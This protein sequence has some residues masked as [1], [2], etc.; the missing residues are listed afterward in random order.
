M[1]IKSLHQILQEH[2]PEC[3]KTN[4]LSTY[5]FKKIAIDISL[6]LFK[7]KASAGDKWITSFMD[8][9]SCLRKWDIHS[10]FIYDGKA[11]LEKFEEQQKRRE[12]QAKQKDNIKELENEILIYEE[13]GK[14][15]D[16]ML[17]ICKKEGI[18]SLFRQKDRIDL[19]VVKEKLEKMKNQ[20]VSITEND[21][22]ISK[23]LFEIM[24][25][26]YIQAPAEAECLASILCIHGKVDAVL[27]EDTDV[28]AYGSPLFLSKIDIF[29]GTVVELDYNCI[30]DKMGMTSASFRD[31]CILLG[32]D[33]NSNVAG[34]GPKKSY[35]LIKTHKNIEEVIEE[36]EKL[37][38]E[39]KDKLKLKLKNTKEDQD[40][41][42]IQ[43]RIDLPF[44]PEVL[45]YRRCREMFAIPDHI[46]FDAPYCGIP[47]FENLSEFLFKNN[48]HYNIEPLKK[49][50]SFRDPVFE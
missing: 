28:L 13:N 42:K 33:Y 7:F 30:L 25:V 16:L 40:K 9:I 22:I 20:A 5:A 12:Q 21:I 15:G 3:Y 48:I 35:Q 43:S 24:N 19:N 31:M 8:L 6:F 38:I 47:D 26:P 50:L 1:G 37:D 36:M 46:D 23:K 44:D 27:S 29:K 45:K 10:V 34:Y 39:H 32:C 11:P 2:A 41:I 17:N 49:N 18:V 4:H 14:I